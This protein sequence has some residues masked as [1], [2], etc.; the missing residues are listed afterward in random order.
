MRIFKKKILLS[1]KSRMNKRRRRESPGD[2]I[3]QLN[4]IPLDLASLGDTLKTSCKIACE[5]SL[6]IQAVVFF[7][8][9]PEFYPLVHVS[10]PGIDFS[11]RFKDLEPNLETVFSLTTSR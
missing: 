1:N 6:C 7:Y 9:S 3:S 8:N 5:I 2:D 4:H 10:H 11:T